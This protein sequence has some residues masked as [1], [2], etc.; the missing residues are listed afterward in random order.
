MSRK[1]CAANGLHHTDAF[2]GACDERDDEKAQEA[3]YTVWEMVRVL[4]TDGTSA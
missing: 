3:V 4:T 1:H 2:K